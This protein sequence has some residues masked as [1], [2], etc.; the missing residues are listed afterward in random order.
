MDRLSGEIEGVDVTFDDITRD[1][2]TLPTL[3]MQRRP[4]PPPLPP[5]PP[6][7]SMASRM[8]DS[9]VSALRD[10]TAPKPPPSADPKI[11]YVWA[12]AEPRVLSTPGPFEAITETD[13]EQVPIRARPVLPAPRG[14]VRR[15]VILPWPAILMLLAI[16]ARLVF[17]HQETLQA[18]L[19]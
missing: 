17:E 14:S 19:P 5:R 8:T 4:P 12:P 15:S 3:R 7:A 16:A 1:I 11:L 13:V 2:D 18:L 9:I 6:Y 10:R